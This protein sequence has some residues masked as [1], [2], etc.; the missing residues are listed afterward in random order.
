MMEGDKWELTL[1]RKLGYGK[2]DAGSS[3]AEG[4]ACV[5]C[6]LHNT[7]DMLT[8]FK[9]PLQKNQNVPEVIEALCL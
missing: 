2:H 1:P 4:V 3:I 9:E 7:N 5:F 8:E 6:E